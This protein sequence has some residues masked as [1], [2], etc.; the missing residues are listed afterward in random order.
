VIRRLDGQDWTVVVET[1]VVA[2]QQR[3]VDLP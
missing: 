1:E 2:G 3:V